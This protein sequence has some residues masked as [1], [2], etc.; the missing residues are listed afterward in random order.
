MRRSKTA[1]GLRSLPLNQAAWDSVLE[2]REMAKP[3]FGENLSLDWYVF[4]YAE[5]YER[6]DPT[7]PMKGCVQPGGA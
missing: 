6:P 4:P 3:L 5:G 7:K 2:L 1:A